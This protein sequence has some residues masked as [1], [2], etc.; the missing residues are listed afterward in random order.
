MAIIE[1][2]EEEEE[3]AM[4]EDALGKSLGEG[5]EESREGESLCRER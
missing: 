1:I 4:R 3:K 2:E 5:E